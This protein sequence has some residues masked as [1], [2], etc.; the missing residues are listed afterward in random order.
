MFL[1]L[2]SFCILSKHMLKV[3]RNNSPLAEQNF[4][5]NQID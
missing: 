2:M 1:S 5:Q 4:H 3:E